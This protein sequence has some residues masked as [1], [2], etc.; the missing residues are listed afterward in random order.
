M[1]KSFV[2]NGIK[3]LI[4]DDKFTDLNIIKIIWVTVDKI[5]KDYIQNNK[6]QE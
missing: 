5:D 2:N 3:K 4:E 6:I 1:I